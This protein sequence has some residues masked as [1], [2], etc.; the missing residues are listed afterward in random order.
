MAKGHL[1]CGRQWLHCRCRRRV[2]PLPLAPWPPLVVN[3]HHGALPLSP[4][5]TLPVFP[6]PRN[7]S[8]PPPPCSRRCLSPHRRRLGAPGANQRPPPGPPRRPLSSRASNRR[9]IACIAATV[10]AF[11]DA[12][13]RASSTDASPSGL[14]GPRR[15]LRHVVGEI[16][17]QLDTSIHL[18]PP[19]VPMPSF[20][21]HRPPSAT[22]VRIAP[23]TISVRSAATDFPVVT[24]FTDAL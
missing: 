22:F 23:A 15:P 8:S 1:P 19:L 2:A 16:A 9:G 10:R 3:G 11:Y 6:H 24:R 20:L 18:L 5:L 13:R 4:S 12:G 14:P 21:R 17:V 7:P